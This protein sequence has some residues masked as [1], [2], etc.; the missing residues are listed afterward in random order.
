VKTEVK[1]S[2][3]RN[4]VSAR[5]ELEAVT[6]AIQ[7]AKTNG[8]FFMQNPFLICAI[9]ITTLCFASLSVN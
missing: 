4:I 2:H 5:A 8:T 6:A 7:I 1:G 3:L 9:A